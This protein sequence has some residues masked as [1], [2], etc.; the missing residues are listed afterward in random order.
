MND[1]KVADDDIWQHPAYIVEMLNETTECL[2]CGMSLKYHKNKEKRRNRGYCSTWC[3]LS[4]PPK[5]AWLEKEYG[6]SIETIILEVLNACGSGQ[7]AA[8]RLGVTRQTLYRWI[9]R[10]HLRQVTYWRVGE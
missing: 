5:M 3:Y 6:Q 4:K 10:L 2:N 7:V 8:D 1:L 9:K